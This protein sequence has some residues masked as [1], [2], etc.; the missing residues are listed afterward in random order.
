[1]YRIL[2]FSD[3]HGR[4]NLMHEII[5]REN[6]DAVLHLGDCYD[7]MLELR[8]CYDFPVHGVMGNVD[9]GEGVRIMNLN[10][11]GRTLLL[12]HGH[13]FRVKQQ[14]HMIKEHGRSLGADVILFGHTHLS[15][16]E[17]GDVI[18]MNP[19][20]ITLPREVQAS[21]GVIEIKDNQIKTEIIHV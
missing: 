12:C 9:H 6:C 19:G 15:Y 4:T 5:Q 8:M 11:E 7:D 10:V 1:M 20:S 14:Y 2:V 21:Y 3:S 13:Q 18:L 17:E 16:L